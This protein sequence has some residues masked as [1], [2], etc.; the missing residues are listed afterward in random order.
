MIQQHP[1]LYFAPSGKHRYGMFCTQDIEPDSVIEICP[2]I[3]IPIEQAGQIIKGHV[4]Y[5]YYFEWKKNTIAI[6]L[7]YGSLYNHAEH[8]NAEFEPDYKNQYIIFRALHAIPAGTEI[9]VDY[10]AGNPDEEVWFEVNQ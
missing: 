2:I 9:L 1:G 3:L 7:G 4:L 10:H 6:A 8:P 5:D